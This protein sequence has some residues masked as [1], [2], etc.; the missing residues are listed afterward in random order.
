[1]RL[2][3]YELIEHYYIFLKMHCM[4]FSYRKYKLQVFCKLKSVVRNGW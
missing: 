4:W 3:V 1:M 2:F